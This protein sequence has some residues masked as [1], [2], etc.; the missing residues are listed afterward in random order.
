MNKNTTLMLSDFHQ[1]FMN[2]LK[3]NPK[4]NVYSSSFSNMYNT[5]V[6][7]LH[8]NLRSLINMKPLEIK[9]VL[10]EKFDSERISIL[11]AQY[12]LDKNISVLLEEPLS[13]YLYIQ[14]INSRL[15]EYNSFREK[16]LDNSNILY[17]F[18]EFILSA[19]DEK[20]AI[21]IKGLT[22]FIN[23]KTFII[24]LYELFKRDNS[25][26]E[27]LLSSPIFKEEIKNHLTSLPYL[28][29]SDDH[30]GLELYIKAVI[31]E[32]NEFLNS[33]VLKEFNKI[34]QEH[35]LLYLK[36]Q[37]F[38]DKPE[39]INIPSFNLFA[40]RN[41]HEVFWENKLAIPFKDLSNEFFKQNI[42]LPNIFKN[43]YFKVIE[44]SN[45]VFHIFHCSLVDK[46]LVFHTILKSNSMEN[47]NKQLEIISDLNQFNRFFLG[48]IIQD[49]QNK[50]NRFSSVLNSSMIRGKD[51]EKLSI[52]KIQGGYRSPTEGILKEFRSFALEKTLSKND[53]TKRTKPKI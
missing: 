43:M 36:K 37:L 7:T 22:S 12:H 39:I 19:P 6:S 13:H 18:S 35:P 47:I 34:N 26:L 41:E 5:S 28:D 51:L 53:E 42:S 52:A 25:I 50:N 21:Y 30:S 31:N 9:N 16:E 23:K 20:K 15:S 45:D 49:F 17:H 46:E 44:N 11:P 33:L 2:Y 27:H 29:S 24:H 32:N 48:I 14:M 10:R 4:L 38:L 3:N 40:A 8:K 1:Y